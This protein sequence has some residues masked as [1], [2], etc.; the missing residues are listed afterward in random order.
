MVAGKFIPITGCISPY[1]W[2]EDDAY[3]IFS[4]SSGG[5]RCGSLQGF[6]TLSELQLRDTCKRYQTSRHRLY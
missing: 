6:G 1:A 3:A 2:D 4:K 5:G